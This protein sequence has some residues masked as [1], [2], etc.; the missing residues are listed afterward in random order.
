MRRTV[1]LFCV[2]LLFA[3]SAI[4]QKASLRE[5]KSKMSQAT[6]DASGAKPLIEAAILDEATKNLA[7]TWYIRGKVYAALKCADCFSTAYESYQKSEELDI[8]NEY[9]LKIETVE[10]PALSQELF[11]Y[12]VDRYNGADYTGALS[13]F[14][15]FTRISPTEPAG[16]QNAAMAAENA[17]DFEKSVRF[18]REMISRKS[19]NDKTYE[20]LSRSLVQL[21]DTAGALEVLKEGKFIYP[22]SMGLMIAEINLLLSA[23]RGN[24]ALS[25]LNRLLIKDPNNL[26]CYLQIGIIHMNLGHPTDAEGNALPLPSDHQLQFTQAEEA[27]KKG[28]TVD[29]G[30]FEINFNLG[31]LYFNEGV[32][33]EK[34]SN[35]KNISDAE[36][37]R[38]KG[39]ASKFYLTAEPYLEKASQVR[40]DDADVLTSLKMLYI[41]TKED[42]KYA[43]VKAALDQLKR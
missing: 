23:N 42:A 36:Y 33:L 40:P 25:T 19:A 17:G 20:S 9:K 15:L 24:D 27:Y 16:F 43:K 3:G 38:L 30:H 35:V 22:D 5:A 11:N 2:C 28:L 29:P 10:L 37:N 4:S 8:R 12:G 31:V 7:E 26:S 32:E 34:A 6:P 39:E 14:E 21:K 13:A 41:R 18:Y 1:I